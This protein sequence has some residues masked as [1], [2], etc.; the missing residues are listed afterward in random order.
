LGTNAEHLSGGEALTLFKGR[1][2]PKS[3]S[4]P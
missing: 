4:G 1:M 3:S 2:M